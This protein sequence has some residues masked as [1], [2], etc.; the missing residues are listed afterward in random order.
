MYVFAPLMRW[1]VDGNR[2]LRS[3]VRWRILF[4]PLMR[5]GV[6]G[7]YLEMSQPYAVLRSP[8]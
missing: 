7:N 1:G 2:H 6:D 4:A 8:R 3:S 5:W